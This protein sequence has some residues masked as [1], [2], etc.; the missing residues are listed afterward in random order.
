MKTQKNYSLYLLLLLLSIGSTALHAQHCAQPSGPGVC[1]PLPGITQM[2]FFPPDYQ[3]PC[4]EIGQPYDTVINFHTPATAQ[5]YTLNWIKILHIDNA[6]CGICWR[7]NDANDKVNGNS[8]GCIR[9]QGITYDAP[10]EYN[11]IVYAD[12]NVTVGF[13]PITISNLNIDSVM[14]LRYY[15]RVRQTNQPCPPVDTLSPGLISHAVGTAPTP[16]ITGA[17]SVCTGATTTLGIS[18]GT[19]YAYQWSTGAV[20]S[21]IQAGAGTY[22]VTAY[23][24]CAS[25]TATKTISTTNVSASITANGPTT[26]CQGGSVT[27]DA[28]TGYT[29]YAWSNNATSQTINATSGGSYT[30]TVTQN[31]CTAASNA[32]VVTITSSP[33]PSLTASGST[34]FC[35]GDSVMLDAGT[36]FSNYLWNNG[37]ATQTIKAI[38]GGSY[39]CNVTQ[40]GCSGMSD[41]ITV[42]VNSISATI[43]ANGPTSFCTGGNV[44]LDAGA[45]Y[46]NYAWSSGGSGQTE[47][48]SASGTYHCTVTQNG[49]QAVSNNITVTVSGSTLSPTITASNG[50]N[51]CSGG[52]TE[53]DA[54]GGYTSYTWSNSSTGQTLVTGTAGNY[55]VTVSQG[56]CTGTASATINVGSFPA[57]VNLS[58]QNP[59][60]C[61]GDVITLDAGVGHSGYN[62]NNAA[63]G[64]TITVTDSGDYVVTVT[65]ANGC[66]GTATTL[67][68]IHSLPSPVLTPSGNPIT[69]CSTDS[70]NLGAGGQY[71]SYLWSNGDTTL[72]TTV[73]AAGTYNVT[74]TQNGCSGSSANAKVVNVV[75]SPVPVISP[76]GTQN[77]CSGH[78]ITLS[79]DSVFASYL[80]SNGATSQSIIVDS[81]G[82]YNVTVTQNSCMGVSTNPSTVFVNLTPNAVITEVSSS[83]HLGVAVLQAS[84]ANATYQWLH[85]FQL[86]GAYD[87]DLGATFNLDTVSCGDVA[88]FYSVVVS[89]NGC[90]DTSEAFT[91]VCTGI[92]DIKTLVNFSVLPNPTQNILTVNYELSGL[93]SVEISVFDYTGRAVEQINYGSQNRGQHS[94]TM[95]LGKLTAGVYIMNFST[96]AGQFNTKIIKQ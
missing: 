58:P 8:T 14:G 95:Q 26:F 91:V 12:V 81:T 88:E 15:L 76:A 71:D 55:T 10:G 85:Q 42:T 34:T 29:G 57:S 7:S 60:G 52:S 67:V 48:I 61:V 28:G 31:G 11:I 74:V 78:P 86:G 79:V 4:M 23:A 90:V 68:A 72:T 80:W 65:D 69:I 19:Y 75:A 66:T 13:F 2:G 50:L 89:Q 22:S 32:T 30:V 37:A 43:T 38:A 1:S 5:G 18:G 45:G 17:N 44:V 93:T 33:H 25:A 56:T 92:N 84:P 64:Q 87:I 96:N 6:P 21:T 82:T 47:T 9:V 27:L 24:N 51:L 20:T 94:A 73:S 62:W 63:N 3:L 49:C 39:Y 77:I 59:T 70:L 41:T 83:S 35:M 54:G 46:S 16:S 53:L 40:N 36:G